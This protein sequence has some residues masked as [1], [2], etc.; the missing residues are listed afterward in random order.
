[1]DLCLIMSGFYKEVFSLIRW[2]QL[3]RKV[4]ANGILQVHKNILLLLE[5][6]H[7]PFKVPFSFLCH[8]C[9]G[10]IPSCLL[11]KSLISGPDHGCGCGGA[12]GVCIYICLLPSLFAP[13]MFS[14]FNSWPEEKQST[15]AI[16]RCS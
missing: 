5:T 4:I 6:F 8:Q 9:D 13:A 12:V 16:K 3:T 7:C 14:A 1:M 11:L 15:Q 10:F 2:N